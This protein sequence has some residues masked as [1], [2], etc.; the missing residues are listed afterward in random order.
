MS[1]T[2]AAPGGGYELALSLPARLAPVTLG[3]AVEG[4][5]GARPMPLAEPVGM[6][7][8]DPTRLGATLAAPPAGAAPN[9]QSVNFAVLSR[10]ATVLSLVLVRRAEGGGVGAGTS[11]DSPAP[12]NGCLEVALDPGLQRTGDVWHVRVDGLTDLASLAWCWRAYGDTA[13]P[14][15]ARFVDG[16]VMLD[17]YAAAVTWLALPNGVNVAPG[18]G[19]AATTNPPALAGTLAG[20]VAPASPPTPRPTRP[21]LAAEDLVVLEVDA[22]TFGDGFD[23]PPD[24][25][26]TLA[27]V[28]A[29]LDAIAALGVTA[30][31]LGGPVAPSAPGPVGRSPLSFFAP[32]PALAAGPDPGAEL[33]A[34]VD[35]AHGRGIEVLLQVEY[36]FTGEG[37]GAGGGGP[38][39]RALSLRGLDAAA[40]Y[41]P[42]RGVLNT[43]TSVVRDLVLA[44]LRHWATRYG[45]DGFVFVNAE[46]LCQ[47][48]G[49]AGRWKG[50][51]RRAGCCVPSATPHQHYAKP[52]KRT[53]TPPSNHI[54]PSQTRTAW[55]WMR[56]HC[57]KPWRPTLCCA[58]SSW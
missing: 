57:P 21:G 11:P 3:F 29:C 36:C 12:T 56:P 9:T 8:G 22:H 51:L 6:G 53:I 44:S 17:P 40:Y 42:G 39:T 35:A 33:L 16:Q 34:L 31:A 45:V 5:G 38:Q 13:A 4:A 26:G 1:P 23:L 47:G 58:A 52:S 37:D 2:K 25:R 55:C 50:C 41:R 32:D 54:Q 43:G 24:L 15:G 46:A 10:H 7:V 18:T 20:L 30:L 49:W 48:E 19:G 14:H 27:G 28:A